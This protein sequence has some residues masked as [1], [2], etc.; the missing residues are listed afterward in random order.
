MGV[1][2]GGAAEGGEGVGSEGGGLG[3]IGGWGEVGG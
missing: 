2:V 3:V 1:G